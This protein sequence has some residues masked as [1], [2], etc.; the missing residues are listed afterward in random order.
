MRQRKETLAFGR[1]SMQVVLTNITAKHLVWGRRLVMTACWIG[2]ESSPR[3]M[4][5]GVLMIRLHHRESDAQTAWALAC[6]P[7]QGFL[8]IQQ[9][10]D[11][12]GSCNLGQLQ[13]L[14]PL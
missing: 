14:L 12:R 1:A 11:G 8:E 10:L 9:K 5:R 6:V 13:F 7:M 3:L 4:V 2:K